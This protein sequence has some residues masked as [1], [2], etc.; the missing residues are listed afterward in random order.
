M[1][2][3]NK[4]NA[5]SSYIALVTE[6]Y[7]FKKTLSMPPRNSTALP[8][9]KSE[10]PRAAI[11]CSK[12]IKIHEITELSHRDMAI[13]VTTMDRKQTAIISL[14]LDIK[15]KPVPEFLI[16]AIE[17]CKKR[18]YSILIGSD[19]NSHSL[20]WDCLLYTSPSPRD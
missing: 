7:C 12:D 2:L 10:H 16:K 5:M 11:F 19:T 9:K 15:D 8:S 18:G 1:E 4:I 14:Y 20:L 13:G 3:L 6:P 17:Y